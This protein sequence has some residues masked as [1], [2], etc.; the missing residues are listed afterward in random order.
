MR[1]TLGSRPLRIDTAASA[2]QSRRRWKTKLNA[3]S[4]CLCVDCFVCSQIPEWPRRLLPSFLVRTASS[5]LCSLSFSFVLRPLCPRFGLS[6]VLDSDGSEDC[7]HYLC[8]HTL[9]TEAVA[10]RSLGRPRGTLNILSEAARKILTAANSS[11]SEGCRM[12]A[13]EDKHYLCLHSLFFK[14]T[15]ISLLTFPVLCFIE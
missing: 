13:Q 14:Q 12:S 6:S 4:V 15:S 3:R 8:F 5:P 11:K 9:Y 1:S 2:D 7:I 10:G